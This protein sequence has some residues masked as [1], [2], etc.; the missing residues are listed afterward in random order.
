M[1]AG[2]NILVEAAIYLTAA[3]VAVPLSKRLGMGSVL[4]YL[5]AGVLIGPHALGLI[6]DPERVLHFAEFGVVML[7]FLI[8]LELE[9]RRLW[10]MR[11]PILGMGAAQVLGTLG[12][13]VAGGLLLGISWQVALVAGMGFAMSSTAIGL[14]T[15]A[16]KGLL[17]APGGKASFSVLLFQDLSV[18][19]LIMGLALLAPGEGQALDPM[20]ALKAVGTIAA[21]I[22]LGRTVLR[23]VMRHIASTGMREIFIAF[24][25]LLVT[26]V[27]L[28]VSAVGLSMALG[29]FLA[30]MLLADSEYRHEL[31]LD[32]EPFKGLLLGLFFIAVGMS[33]DL[34]FIGAHPGQ[35]AGLASA[36]VGL[37]LLFLVGLA[38]AFA[39]PKN[40]AL[41]FGVSLSQ[42][43]EFAFVLFGLARA[44]GT[45]D[46][47]ALNL[48]NATTAASM[49]STP[50]AFILLER[51]TTRA[52]NTSGGQADAIEAQGPVIIA[53][54]GRFGQ[55]VARL[56]H[57][58]GIPTTVLDHDPNQIELV[59]RFGYKAY[60]GDATRYEL[61]ELAGITKARLILLALNDPEATLKIVQD[62]QH[63]LPDLPI[64]ARARGRID[65]LELLE[66]KV[67]VVRET[68]GSALKAATLSL[69]ALGMSSHAAWRL[70][71]Q[72]E[73]HDEQMIQRSLELR[74]DQKALIGL[75]QQGRDELSTLLGNET[76]RS[77]DDP[78]DESWVIETFPRR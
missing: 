70:S 53:G 22:F 34:G 47:N 56:L 78:L 52:I 10:A 17:N 46:A 75:S 64:I 23:H 71:R 69:E 3:V 63:H 55:I 59:R 54:F 32:I 27:A 18:I 51:Y 58:R 68:F 40:D 5:L 2:P 12:L 28:A 62:I 21:I 45:L 60:Y 43:G 6:P 72:F 25:L 30:G 73:R 57:A 49:L 42:V 7:L 24:S 33:V 37:K 50:L 38:R 11:V 77:D 36:V 13:T 20:A 61:L 44:Q 48:V 67:Q 26:G 16:E 14:A 31:E 1:S 8:G 76:L 9:P 39:L 4:G 35:V 66:R 65:A 74:H 15:L 41:L 29:T 19:P